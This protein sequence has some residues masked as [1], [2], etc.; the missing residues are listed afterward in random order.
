MN[1]T[2]AVWTIAVLAALARF[3]GA[4]WPL[5]PD[6]A[7]FLLVARSWHPTADSLYGPYFV[8]RPP[9]L[10]AVVKA[11][12]AA[13]GPYALR[14][15]AALGCSVA[16][17]LAAACAREIAHH[18]RHPAPAQLV[19]R[20][21]VGAAA[22]VA[23]F[24]ATPQIDVVAAKG[25]LLGVPVLLAGHLCALRA[26]RTASWRHAAAAG[27]L[28]AVALGLKQSLIGTLVLMG[29]MLIAA[30]VR[31]R[32]GAR[33][34][35]R[36]AAATALGAAIPLGATAAWAVA[37]GVRLETLWRTVVTFRSE[38]S[39]VLLDQPSG[40]VSERAATLALVFGT[41]GMLLIV[42][43]FVV[44][45]RRIAATLPGVGAAIC[46]LA[47]SDLAAVATSGSYW[48]PYLFALVPTLGLMWACAVLAGSPRTAD[49]P[50]RH[51]PRLGLGVV[52]ACAASAVISLIGFMA[53]WWVGPPP[54]QAL[55]GHEL[56]R[57]SQPGD[58]LLVYGGRA[59]VQWASGLPSPYEHL[60]S[61]PMRTLDPDLSELRA[62][63]A[64]PDAPTW[65]VEVAR[66]DA[67]SELGTKPIKEEL[68]S[69][70]TYLGTVCGGLGVYRLDSAPPS[71]PISPPC[72]DTWRNFAWRG[73]PAG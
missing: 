46:V 31:H 30:L 4:L 33:D 32:L 21:A 22:L 29:A 52:G 23:A 43:A 56:G 62:V 61:L 66:I 24:L 9:L 8:D 41:T 55:L 70:Y 10:I 60:W 40:A 19:D 59:D 69:R 49:E 3:P 36:L 28:G 47:A 25:E 37:A 50:A 26:V 12:D 54:Q 18:A 13:A 57:V 7:G 48:R 27:F 58:S 72:D 39:R 73:L 17:L 65:L 34:F 67:W 20:A 15:V 38:A 44:R 1:P 16:V 45:S 42:V 2:R 71:P 5:R 51:R 35:T 6:E 14:L 63:L 53:I 68:L 11:V 64:G